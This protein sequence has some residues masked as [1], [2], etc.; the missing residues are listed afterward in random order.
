MQIAGKSI[1]CVKTPEACLVLR[2]LKHWLFVLHFT[3]CLN[4]IFPP[5]KSSLNALQVFALFSS[6]LG[7]LYETRVFFQPSSCPLLQ[8]YPVL[9][10]EMNIWIYIYYPVL[11]FQVDEDLMCQICLQPFVS[12]TETPCSHTFCQVRFKYAFCLI[13]FP[14]ETFTNIHFN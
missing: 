1:P 2:T 8:K 13:H 7:L 10:H 4:Y 5:L 6:G 11:L 14:I 12:P 9:L 3:F